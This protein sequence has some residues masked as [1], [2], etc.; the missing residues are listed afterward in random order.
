MSI[1]A[2][3]IAILTVHALVLTVEAGDTEPVPP[4][5]FTSSRTTTENHNVTLR[6]VRVTTDWMPFASTGGWTQAVSVKE[7]ENL[8]YYEAAI[9]EEISAVHFYEF[10]ND[11]DGMYGHRGGVTDEQ[12]TAYREQFLISKYTDMPAA[13][14]EARST[15]MKS[16]FVDIAAYLV[17]EHPDSEHHLMYSGHGGPGGKLFAAQLYENHAS[18]FLKSWTQALGRP[19]GVIDMGGPCNKGSFADLENFS[20]YAGYYVASD[21]PNGGYTMDRWTAQKHDETDPETQYHSLF[22]VNE[23]LEDALRGRIDLKRTAYEYSRDNMIANRVAQANYLY[24]CRAFRTFSFGFKTFLESAT[25]SY[26][27][28]DDLYQYMVDNGASATLLQ[29]FNSVI[30]HKADNKDFFEWSVVRNGLLMP[31]PDAVTFPPVS[32]STDFNGDGR[33]DFVDFLLFAEAFGGADV[34]FDLDGNGTVDFADF[35][36]FVD[37]FGV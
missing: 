14:T 6:V 35:L 21:L 4:I 31:G 23:N 18:E 29:Q 25:G 26:G 22:S 9:W 37:A 11:Y 28:Q 24:S 15:F 8:K 30:V 12:K 10:P 34:R 17:N 7:S 3:R 32:A 16:A 2:L 20:E 36:K 13:W 19:L 33:T 27:I 5:S 1:Y